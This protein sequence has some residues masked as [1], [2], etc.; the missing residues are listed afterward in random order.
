M[1]KCKSCGHL[2]EEGEQK[3]IKENMGE[4]QGSFA[5]KS[6]SGCPCCGGDYETK[7]P[8]KICGTYE[9]EGNGYCNDCKA[10]VKKR[11]SEFLDKEF[12]TDEREL[13]NELY[14]GER[15]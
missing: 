11:F 3:I 6:Y 15:L 5:V 14:D 7:R 1:Y 10:D 4:F 12:T 9:F 8:C 2:F 13:L